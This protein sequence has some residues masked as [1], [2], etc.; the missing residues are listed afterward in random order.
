MT[1]DHWL[2]GKSEPVCSL[3]QHMIA[4]GACVTEY[5]LAPSMQ[6]LLHRISEWLCMPESEAVNLMADVSSLHDIGKAHPS[7]QNYPGDDDEGWR[8]QNYRHEQ[9]GAEVL[10]RQWIARGWN[11]HGVRFLAAL[12]RLHHQGRKLRSC[13]SSTH[14]CIH[15]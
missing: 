13:K 1:Y 10:R 9:F 5:L 15:P 3:R 2:W 12:V 7:F 6:M 8:I 11:R 4:V 14:R